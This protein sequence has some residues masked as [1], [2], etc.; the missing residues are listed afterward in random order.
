VI[1]GA[2]S[3]TRQAMQLGQLPQLTVKQTSADARGQFYLPIVNWIL[4]TAAIGLVLA[5]RSSDNLAG[6]YGVAVNSTMAIKTVLAFNVARER[7]DWSLPAVL[8][9]LFGFLAI[10]LGFLGS[11]LFKITDG[12]WLPLFIGVL[13]F[14][15]MT[16]W[17]RGSGILAE[18]IANAT[19]NLETFIGR[20]K[21]EQIPRIPGTAVFITG[22]LEPTPPSLQQLVRHTG[23]LYE[24]VIL[25]TVVIEPMP[26]VNLD[27]RIELEAFDE[28]FY[29]IMLHYGFMHTPNIPSDLSACAELGLHLDLD[30]IHYIVGHVD[31]LAGRK[32][33]G[34]AVW[35]DKLFVF[36]ARNTKD[37]IAGYHIPAAQTMT[38]GL[39]VGI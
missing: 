32:L 18:Q 10:D 25:M 31:L 21:G 20:V 19:T 34:M 7:G 38:V 6:A 11:N 24:R 2:F 13:L 28:G 17:R 9:F 12:G 37:A 3:L 27:E 39:H 33:H 5:F 16:T 8:A 23:V 1:T 30:E 29:R 15:V 4:M 36:L 14:T 26:T 22:R 35:R